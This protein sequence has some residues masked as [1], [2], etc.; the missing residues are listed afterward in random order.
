KMSGI[1]IEM[2]KTSAG[3]GEPGY[4]AYAYKQ[5]AMY[6]VL[7]DDVVAEW[8][9]QEETKAKFAKRNRKTNRNVKDKGKKKESLPMD[10]EDSDLEESDG[11][12]DVW[13]DI[14]TYIY[15]VDDED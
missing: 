6:Q 8:S 4:A 14:D 3:D 2:A 13:D 1:W 12:D 7:H 5:A 11:D 9:K 15:G 10:L